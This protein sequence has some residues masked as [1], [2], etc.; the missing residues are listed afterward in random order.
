MSAAIPAVPFGRLTVVEWRKQLDTR[1]GRWLLMTI[2]IVTAAV[3]AIMAAVN[4]GN[5]SFGGFL[6]GTSTPLLILLPIVGVLAATAEWS[7]RTALVTFTLEPRRTRVG[8]AKLLSAM[9]S[10]AG[11]FAVAVGLAALAHLA[12]VTLRGADVAWELQGQ[13]VPGMLLLI[14]LGM[15]QGVGFGLLLLNTPAAIVTLLVLPTVFGIVGSLVPGMA[16]VLPWIDLGTAGEPLLLGDSLSGEGWARIA[17][18]A[19]IWV[20]VPLVLGLVRVARSEIRSA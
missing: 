12:V 7:Q 6:V 8:L 19:G 11:F 16:D 20:V 3:L 2:A 18:A 15:A 17:T 5:H 9:G 1:A 13:L 14:V 10:G 4:G